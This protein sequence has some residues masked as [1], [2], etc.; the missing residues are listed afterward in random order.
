MNVRRRLRDAALALATSR[1]L[2]IARYALRGL[3]ASRLFQAFFLA[4][5]V[6]SLVTLAAISA[7]HNERFDSWIGLLPAELVR[8]VDAWLLSA[9]LSPALAI[10]FLVTLVAGPAIIAP[11]LANN[12]MPLLLS[13]PLRKLDY[14]LGK[15]LALLAA[16]GAVTWLPGALLLLVH[17]QYAEHRPF[18]E[19]ARLALALT[20]TCLAWSTCIATIALAIA[21]WVKSRPVATLGFLGLFFVGDV[22]G[23]L[24]QAGV[25]GWAGSAFDLMEAAQVAGRTLYGL[26]AESPMPPGAAWTMLALSAAVAGFALWRRI[27]AQEVAT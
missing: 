12:A 21:A 5:Y 24:V 27:R 7:R 20:A 3:F 14:V 18:G 6:P 13:R 19:D 10:A 17:G 8:N 25:G 11:D 15:L 16:T 2:V 4:C 9:T 1:A 23:D 26:R 22:I